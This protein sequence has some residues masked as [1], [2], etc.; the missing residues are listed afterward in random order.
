M[1]RKNNKYIL[2]V[3][4]KKENRDLLSSFFRKFG[5]KHIT[6]ESGEESIEIMNKH[7]EIGIILMDVKM[8]GMSG[9]EAMKTIKL[10]SDVPIIAVTA[11]AMD[12]DREY[13]INEGFDD[14]ISKPIDIH[15]LCNKIDDWLGK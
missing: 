9:T 10:N 13:L 6:A 3:D 7:N 4:D 2:I 8:K 15:L 5:Q 11:F 1:I 14:F 12:S